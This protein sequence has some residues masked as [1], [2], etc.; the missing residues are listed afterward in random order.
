MDIKANILCNLSTV[1]RKQIPVGLSIPNPN[2]LCT[3]T[4]MQIRQKCY[5]NLI[6]CRLYYSLMC[7]TVEIIIV[8]Q[9]TCIKFNNYCYRGITYLVY[10]NRKR[11]SSTCPAQT[12]K[13][14]ANISHTKSVFI[15]GGYIHLSFIFFILSVY[16]PV[17]CGHSRQ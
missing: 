17:A 4:C 13:S 9:C 12:F 11:H 14:R 15:R 3:F 8:I 5:S 6:Y 7:T 10:T 1:K 2:L 16:L